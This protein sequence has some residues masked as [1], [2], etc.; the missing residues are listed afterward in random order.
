MRDE[1][2]GERELERDERERG[3]GREKTLFLFSPLLHERA[4]RS[5]N[6]EGETKEVKEGSWRK[7]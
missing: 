2:K 4:R 1:E 6:S 5:G 7:T 3:S